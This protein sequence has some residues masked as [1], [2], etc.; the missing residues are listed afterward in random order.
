MMLHFNIQKMT[1]L[2]LEPKLQDKKNALF[3]LD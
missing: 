1:I 2:L 3:F